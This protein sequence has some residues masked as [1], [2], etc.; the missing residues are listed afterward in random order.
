M[1]PTAAIR[2]DDPGGVVHPSC[3]HPAHVGGVRLAR[4]ARSVPGGS[5]L[6]TLAVVLAGCCLRARSSLDSAA[7]VACQDRRSWRVVARSCSSITWRGEFRRYSGRFSPRWW[8]DTDSPRWGIVTTRHVGDHRHVGGSSRP[9]PWSEFRPPGVSGPGRVLLD[10][11]GHLA[12]QD[13]RSWQVAVRSCSSIT[14]CGEFRRYSGCFSPQ[15]WID[16]DSPRWWIVTRL[17]VVKIRVQAHAPVTGQR[18]GP[19]RARS[20]GP[21]RLPRSPILASCCSVVLVDHLAWRVSTVFGLFLAT[22]VD[23]H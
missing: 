3:A 5:A 18:A 2:Y 6:M 8:I 10:L 14:W 19:G 1:P 22:L 13:R 11:A 20:C 12:C 21:P 15:W 7:H 16:T 4:L 17:A 23:R 9:S